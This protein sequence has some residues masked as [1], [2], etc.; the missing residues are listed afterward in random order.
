MDKNV[1]VL[2][3]FVSMTLSLFSGCIEEENINK[4]PI[5]EITYPHDG[6]IV[7]DLIMISGVWR[8]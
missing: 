2:L 7:S 5:V 1:I 8:K 4:K 3:I 6:M